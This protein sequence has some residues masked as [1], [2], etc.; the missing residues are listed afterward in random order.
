MIKSNC[1]TH[2]TY[3][4]GKN[5]LEEMIQSAIEKRFDSIGFS[6]HSPMW[7]E[8][9]W[10]MTQDKF[11]EYINE[12]KFLK[13]KYRDKIDILC[14]AELDADYSDTD[15]N[16]LDYIICSVH[17]F[18]RNGK[19]YPIDYSPEYLSS[20]V[21]ELFGGDWNKMCSAYF[22]RLSD[23]VVK[24]KPQVV[25]HFDIITKYN[26]AHNLFDENNPEYQSIALSAVDKILDS[27][28]DV[29][30]EVNT[31]AMY[32]NGNSKPY[33]AEFIMKHLSK[34]NAKLTVT[35]DSHCV[36][37][38][39]FAFDKAIEYCK[40]NGFNKL[41]SLCSKGVVEYEI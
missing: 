8:S 29:L 37:S 10:A 27:D 1:H 28:K 4:D 14:G 5:T 13:S 22:E 24:I 30:F 15:F 33:P 34:R 18:I 12:L 20:L 40:S 19:D 32:R 38:L 36:E 17:Q 3:C 16:D 35:S 6:G 39:D 31:G 11:N 25:G 21:D 26:E 9:D 2:S 7:F 23:F 41:Y